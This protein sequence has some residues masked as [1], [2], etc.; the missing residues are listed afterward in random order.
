MYASRMKVS[1]LS[2]RVIILTLES[3]FVL[4]YRVQWQRKEQILTRVAISAPFLLSNLT[5]V[6][7]NKP[8]FTYIRP[9]S[10]FRINSFKL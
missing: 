7:E 10:K 1:L 2:D 5:S 6:L 4:L 3:Y 9:I 8:S